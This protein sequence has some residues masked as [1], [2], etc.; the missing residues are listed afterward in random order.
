MRTGETEEEGMNRAV[1][2]PRTAAELILGAIACVLIVIVVI[3]VF[4]S[5]HQS[6]ANTSPD[7]HSQEG[8]QNAEGNFILGM[9][10]LGILGTFGIIA[11]Y[12]RN[13]DFGSKK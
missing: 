2:M 1:L 5:S 4:N 3:M 8:I 10:I 11:Y 12:Y 13:I 7:N 6:P 9:A